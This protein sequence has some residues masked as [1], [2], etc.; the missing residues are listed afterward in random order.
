M[1]NGD[2][3]DKV[4]PKSLTLSREALRADLAE[5]ELR[6][7]I[8]IG[9]ELGKKADETEL[10]LLK[11]SFHDKVMQDQAFA[12]L[13]DK[14][15]SEHNAMLAWQL[16]ANMGHFTEAQVMT[17][18]ARAKDVL[19]QGDFKRW[20]SRQRGLA[21]LGGFLV[22]ATFVLHVLSVIYFQ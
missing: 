21:Y 6:L 18:A 14:L 12:L 1:P 4:E 2:A 8:W 7:R 10:D 13:K 16:E 9:T 19:D 15:I 5:M 11:K 22:S 17:M 3:A 20:T